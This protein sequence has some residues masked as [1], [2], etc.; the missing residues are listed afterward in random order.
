MCVFWDFDLQD[1]SEKG[2]QL[3]KYLKSRVICHCNHLTNFAV[4]IVS[5]R[6]CH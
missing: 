4:L 3:A 6:G 1:W 2:C 5:Y